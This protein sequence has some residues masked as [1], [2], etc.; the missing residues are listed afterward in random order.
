MPS[1]AVVFLGEGLLTPLCVLTKTACPFPFSAA[2]GGPIGG[3]ASLT[4]LAFKG[5]HSGVRLVK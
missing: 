1:S 5:K 2:K 3:T 4:N